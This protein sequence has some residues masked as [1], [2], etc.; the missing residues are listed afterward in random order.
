MKIILP[1]RHP[2]THSPH[3]L[4]LV[5]R[6]FDH[7]LHRA[8][9]GILS[10]IKCLHSILQLEAMS[11]HW[12]QIYSARRQHRQGDRVAVVT[13]HLMKC[14]NSNEKQL[15][16]FAHNLIRATHQLASR[17]VP[18]TSISWVAACTMG[19]VIVGRPIPTIC[20]TPPER[21]A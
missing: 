14:T 7:D 10:H 16:T 3:F 9:V 6:A 21:V 1:P 5:T 4:Y 20:T 17:Q 11:N 2:F 12:L 13:T 15:L 19:M 18:R 8:T